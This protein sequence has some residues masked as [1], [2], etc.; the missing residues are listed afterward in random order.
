ML[1]PSNVWLNFSSCI[2]S[3]ASGVKVPPAIKG[4]P[5]FRYCGS[6]I[7]DGQSRRN[8]KRFRRGV[9]P[10][11]LKSRM[12]YLWKSLRRITRTFA[13]RLISSR[14]RML[15][16]T[17][18]YTSSSTSACTFDRALYSRYCYI[19]TTVQQTMRLRLGPFMLSFKNTSIRGEDPRL[20]FMRWSRRYTPR[21]VHSVK[22][23]SGEFAARR[24]VTELLA[25]RATG[26]S[27]VHVLCTT[28]GSA[29][30]YI[31]LPNTWYPSVYVPPLI[32]RL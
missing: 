11:I 24:G 16:D 6:R 30:L 27:S 32:D 5:F 7:V 22:H 19:L 8:V 13:A 31:I 14:L 10:Y 4:S 21:F 3:G 1:A 9:R 17:W 18:H 29:R 12:Y 26:E 2:V 23:R 28:R 25:T 20:N 15:Y